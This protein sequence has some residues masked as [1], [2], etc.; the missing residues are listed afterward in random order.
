M[1]CLTLLPMQEVEV[2][3]TNMQPTVVKLVV[4]SGGNAL[5][6]TD[7]PV[8]VSDLIAALT[9]NTEGTITYVHVSDDTLAGI[10]TDALKELKKM[11]LYLA[12]MNDTTIQNRDVEV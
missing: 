3:K 5:G 4:E 7:N 6:E 8:I 1:D 12:M 9:Q 11:N 10:M 2:S